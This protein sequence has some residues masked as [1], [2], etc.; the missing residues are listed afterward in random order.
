MATCRCHVK[1]G[2]TNTGCRSLRKPCREFCPASGA[3]AGV[4]HCDFGDCPRLVHATNP[5]QLRRSFLRLSGLVMLILSLCFATLGFYTL[6][7]YSNRFTLSSLTLLYSSPYYFSANEEEQV[8]IAL[9]NVTDDVITVTVRLDE[10]NT[11]STLAWVEDSNIVLDGTIKAHEQK[12]RT[13]KV[14]FPFD[15]GGSNVS[16]PLGRTAGL[17]FW[18][19]VNNQPAA[20]ILK[21]PV[22][23]APIPWMKTIFIGI[24]PVLSGLALW[25]VKEWWDVTKTQWG[26]E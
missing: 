13:V 22:C 15:I 9:I 23:V 14:L 2:E 25:L 18:A 17:S 8:D 21:L 26:R 11:T 7:R 24:L 4:F 12:E 10:D 3:S 16:S 5:D 20:S 6:P 1:D 19:N